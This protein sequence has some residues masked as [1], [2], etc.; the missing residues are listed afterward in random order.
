MMRNGS[1]AV[2]LLVLASLVSVAGAEAEDGN[3]WSGYILK[4]ATFTAVSA[5]WT[6]PTVVCTTKDAR[7]SI[8]VGLDGNG[9]PTV[10]QVGTVAVCGKTSATPLYY[11]AFWEMYTSNK[12]DKRGG[13]PFLV[14][15]GDTIA[16]SVSY[17]NGSYVLKLEDVTN[18]QQFSQP[19]NCSAAGAP[20]P[21]GLLNG[22]VAVRIRSRITRRWRSTSGG[23]IKA[24]VEARRAPK[25]IW[26]TKK[27]S[28]SCPT[29][30]SLMRPS[31]RQRPRSCRRWWARSKSS[32]PPTLAA[33][34]WPQNKRAARRTAGSAAK[35][36]HSPARGD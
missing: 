28:A 10:E 17:N 19:A 4:G 32:H 14:S 27:P 9:T 16:A 22:R 12:A 11:K 36:K 20:P 7:V 15:P 3:S 21:N 8:W 18:G 34:G 23:T 13:K 35:Q 1:L 2:S 30:A 5:M 31:R 6:Q 29:V 26:S 33:A 24:T 25:S